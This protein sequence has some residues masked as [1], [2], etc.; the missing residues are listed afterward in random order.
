HTLRGTI[1]R[2]VPRPNEAINETWI[3]DRDRFSYEGIYSEERLQTPRMKVD[4]E[5]RD[6][7]WQE[8][9]EAA[10]STL[11][12]AG[13]DTA[14]IVSPSATLEEGFLLSRLATHLGTASIDHRLSRR[15]NRD[16]TSDP[17]Y[18]YLGMSIEALDSIDG[19]LI[20]GSHLR[21]E[22]PILAHRLRKAAVDK[23][24]AIASVDTTRHE[25]FFPMLA[26]VEDGLVAGVAA[27]L[28]AAADQAG[29]A[30]PAVAEGF[31]GSVDVTEAHRRAA[32]ALLEKDNALL[33]LGL[34]AVSHE[35]F[36]ELRLLAVALADLT[37]ATLGYLSEGA[38]S[39]GL[40]LAGVL[41]HRA[42]NGE[43]RETAGSDV[44]D[45]V[46][47]PKTAT[48]LWNVEL[49][50]LAAVNAGTLQASDMI[51]S[52][53]PFFDER[54]AGVADIVMPIGSFAETAG[55]FVNVE[56]RAQSWHGI[57]TPIGEAR[58]GWKVLRVLGN[59]LELPD[60]EYTDAAAVSAAALTLIGIREGDNHYAGE[61]SPQHVNGEDASDSMFEKSIYEVDSVV[62]RARAL[63][64]TRAGQEGSAHRRPEMSE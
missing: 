15:D 4:G 30:V 25:Y 49:E 6:V 23:G 61:Y 35:A 33:L 5:W 1:K 13:N 39:A 43:A 18:P 42:A 26:Q 50:D 60:C 24:A 31:V 3:A 21:Q 48:V 10:A 41:P 55:T 7:S 8:A 58:P 20:V 17:A 14:F 36:S 27:I 52:F 44:A 46:A 53:S 38:N 9:L 29:R 64:L 32:G 19:A 45:M 22:A 40:S 57:A 56:G 47:N 62:R 16:Q 34:R 12:D 54:T 2:I 28:K 63:Q 37:G 59:A 11:R 51:I